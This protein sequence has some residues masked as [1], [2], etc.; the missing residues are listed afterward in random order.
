MNVVA[1]RFVATVLVVPQD[2]KTGL[3]HTTDASSRD[4]GV[5]T[6]RVLVVV[7]EVLVDGETVLRAELQLDLVKLFRGAA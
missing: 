1:G 2:F 5:M 7:A 6:G 3:A 4:A